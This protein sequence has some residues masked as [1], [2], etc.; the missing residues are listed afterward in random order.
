VLEIL[1]ASG[2][3]ADLVRRILTFSRKQEQRRSVIRLQPVLAEVASL[4][5]ASLPTTI[6]IVQHLDPGCPTILA[7]PT[8]LHQIVMNLSTNSAYAM[9]DNGGRLEIALERFEADAEFARI[10]PPLRAG[11]C[12]RLKI[13]DTGCGM[14]AATVERIFEPF[15]TTKPVGHGTGLGLSVVHGIVQNHEGAITVYSEPDKGTTFH[16][17]FPAAARPGA[18]PIKPATSSPP[19]RGQRILFVDD[20]PA[21][22]SFARRMLERIGYAPTICSGAPEALAAFQGAPD[23]FQ[24]VVT[25]LTM[26]Q[27]TGL[28]L[29]AQ[30]HQL[31]PSLPI[32]LITG[33]AGTVDAAQAHETGIRHFLAKPFSMQSLGETLAQIL[34]QDP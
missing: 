1:K 18:E 32:I 16:L 10:Y 34:A 30:L 9:R 4:L 29:A 3:A 27:M 23:E 33:Y 25:D 11:P 24:A 5:R 8:Q 28:E 21:I 15:F 19:G 12:V 14:D 13:T 6:E 22:T 17:F 26:P 20:E 31:R 2:R 7:D